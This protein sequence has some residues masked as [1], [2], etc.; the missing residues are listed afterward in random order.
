MKKITDW[1][2]YLLIFLVVVKR[3]GGDNEKKHKQLEL[4]EE[5]IARVH[6]ANGSNNELENTELDEDVA[7]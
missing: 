5:I 2:P 7:T 1:A 3:K 6:E 4:L